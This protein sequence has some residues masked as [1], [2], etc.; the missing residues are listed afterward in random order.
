VD[1]L[2]FGMIWFTTRGISLRN[3]KKQKLHLNLERAGREVVEEWCSMKTKIQKQSKN[4]MKTSGIIK[5]NWSDHYRIFAIDWWM[6]NCE[7]SVVKI[8]SAS[9]SFD[10]TC[11]RGDVV[12]HHQKNKNNLFDFDL[13][14]TYSLELF[15]FMHNNHIIIK[16]VHYTTNLV[17]DI[18]SITHEIFYYYNFQNVSTY[19]SKHQSKTCRRNISIMTN[20]SLFLMNVCITTIIDNE[21]C[22][23]DADMLLIVA[24]YS[25]SFLQCQYYAKYSMFRFQA[26]KSHI[27]SI[28]K[29]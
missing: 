18:T 24:N 1:V 2:R 11:D 23:H 26:F 13:K 17:V 28:W 8:L 16:T 20:I 15:A 10:Q 14:T 21:F 22:H 27:L 5:W 29:T 4:R 25:I 9:F 7:N 12:Q 6:I 3:N 19:Q